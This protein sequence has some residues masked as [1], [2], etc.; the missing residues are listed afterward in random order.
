MPV[1]LA[2]GEAVCEP[3]AAHRFDSDSH[4]C[5]RCPAFPTTSVHFQPVRLCFTDSHSFFQIPKVWRIST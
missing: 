5:R 2:L 4:R 3:S 1:R